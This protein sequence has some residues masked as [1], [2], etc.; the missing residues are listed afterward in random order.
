MVFYNPFTCFYPEFYQTLLVRLYSFDGK[1][2]TPTTTTVITW[3]EEQS[4]GTT[5]RK[6]TDARQFTNYT[7]AQSYI[8]DTS[9]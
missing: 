1:A 7:D 3:T 8:R 5:Y 2:V 9:G 4:N 6:V